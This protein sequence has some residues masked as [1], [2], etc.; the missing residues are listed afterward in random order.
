MTYDDIKNMTKRI[1][2]IKAML[3]VEENEELLRELDEL[4]IKRA[5]AISSI[6]GQTQE[7]ACL[8]MHLRYGYTWRKIATIVGGGNSANGIIKKCTRFEW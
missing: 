3:G 1:D 7:G 2:D 6:P 8:L 5:D 4:Y